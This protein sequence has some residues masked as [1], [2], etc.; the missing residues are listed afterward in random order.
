MMGIEET[1]MSSLL[2]HGSVEQ[3]VL[4]AVAEILMPR[5][6]LHLEIEQVLAVTSTQEQC[7]TIGDGYELEAL[8]T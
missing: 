8:L 6:P 2:L 1:Q 5:G 3:V 7:Q 4:M